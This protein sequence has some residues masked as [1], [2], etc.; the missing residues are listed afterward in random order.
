MQGGEDGPEG[1]VRNVKGLLGGH[2]LQIDCVY[3]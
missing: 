2:I 3:D 1:G